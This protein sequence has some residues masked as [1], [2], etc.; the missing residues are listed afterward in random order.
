MASDFVIFFVKLGRFIDSNRKEKTKD[1]LKEL[2]QITPLKAYL[3]EG[4]GEREVT[5]DEVK[6]GDLLVCKPGMKVAVDGEVVS[7]ESYLDQAFLTG[8]SVP[9]K[10][11]KGD[12]VLAGSINQDG[13]FE[14]KALRIGKN[15]TISEMVR[16]VMGAANTTAPM[17]R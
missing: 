13:Y 12:Q 6:K 7:G 8:E 4:K 14:Y 11:K 9:V 5:I 15:S 10:K 16:M 3:K 2:V 1:A 17:A